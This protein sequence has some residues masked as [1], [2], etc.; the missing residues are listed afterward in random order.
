MWGDQR[1]ASQNSFRLQNDYFIQ[2]T[3]YSFKLEP[4]QN[5]VLGVR[6]TLCITYLRSQVAQASLGTI[7]PY[8][9]DVY[10]TAQPLHRPLTISVQ[11]LISSES[12]LLQS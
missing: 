8:T 2:T 3:Y 1:P 6:A 5:Q 9:L 10:L 12:S 7:I 11:T 4:S